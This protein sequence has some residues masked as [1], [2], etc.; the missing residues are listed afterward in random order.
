[1]SS[2][3]AG[4]LTFEEFERLPDPPDGGR[5]ELLEGELSLVPPPKRGHKKIQVK[6]ARWCHR[7]LPAEWE[8]SEAFGVRVGGTNY[9]IPDIAVFAT[10][11]WDVEGDDGYFEGAPEL[12]VEVLS[13][14][15]SARG[16]ATKIA[17]YFEHGAQECWIVDPLDKRVTV[18]SIDQGTRIYTGTTASITL[19]RFGIDEPL[20]LSVIFS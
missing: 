5:Y 6:L 20:P 8:C 16:I 7:N 4:L 17:L 2:T 19:A 14:S 18:H 15:N 9:L 13:P 1:M 3:V 10:A 12:A 11:R